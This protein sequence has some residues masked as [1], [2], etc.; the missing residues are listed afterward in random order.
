VLSTS[1]PS[2]NEPVLELRRSSVRA[3]L[4]DA[5]DALDRQLPLE[6]PVLVGDD[7]LTSNGGREVE[8]TDPGE[9]DRLV[10]RG[11]AT[12]AL[13]VDAAVTAAAAGFRAWRAIRA[14]DR[15]GALLR[16]AGHL[17]EHRLELAALE[18]RECAKPWP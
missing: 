12:A 7:A 15:A 18:V 2:A 3:S 10:A 16:A 11:V 9:P 5:L 6:V 1:P 4:A 17:R 14:S 8:S 13:E